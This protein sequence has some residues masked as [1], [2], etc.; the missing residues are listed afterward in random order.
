MWWV[1]EA[2]LRAGHRVDPRHGPGILVGDPRRP[3]GEADAVRAVAGRVGGH[4]ASALVDLVGLALGLVGH[5]R[6]AAADGRRRSSGC[7]SA[8]VAVTVLDAASIRERPAALDTQTAPSAAAPPYASEEPGEAVQHAPA[9]GIDAQDQPVAWAATPRAT[10]R[11]RAI[12]VVRSVSCGSA[13]TRRRRSAR[14]V[15]ESISTTVGPRP[16]STHSRSRATREI[17]DVLDRRGDLAGDPPAAGIDRDERHRREVEHPEPPVAEHRPRRAAAANRRGATTRPSAGSSSTTPGAMPAP[18][19]R[20]PPGTAANT[21]AAAAASTTATTRARRRIRAT[22]RRRAARRAAERGER[23]V[24]AQDRALQLAQPRARLEPELLHEPG[25]RVAIDRQRLLLA[26]RAVEREHQL[27]AQLLAQRMLAR[28]RVELGDQQR[29]ARRAPAPRRSA[30][31]PRT[32]AA[33]RAARARAAR[34]R[35]ARRRPVRARAT[36]PRPPAAARSGQLRIVGRAPGV[37]QRLESVASRAPPAR[38]AADSRAH[39]VSRRDSPSTLRRRETWLV[40]V[41]LAV[42]DSRRRSAL[43]AAAHAARRGWRSAAGRRAARAGAVR[44]PRAAGPG[45]VPRAAPG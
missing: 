20:P 44:R 39:C 40:S 42:S 18:G 22:A 19:P 35:R 10:R 33:P 1:G 9:G 2:A 16:S 28:E 37:Q 38:P 7:G 25:A 36:G 41:W 14:P 17:A 21:A 13:L 24:L 12:M 8:A 45:P 43:R 27:A 26:P 3:G 15:R 23:R 30:L 29:H 31:R 6:E 32:A 11:P 34:R 5:P 4:D